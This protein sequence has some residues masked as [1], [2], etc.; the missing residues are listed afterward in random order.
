MFMKETAEENG[1]VMIN[2]GVKLLNKVNNKVAL[3]SVDIFSSYYYVATRKVFSRFFYNWP[4][5]CGQK[6]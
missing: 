6:R 3:T 4:A 2:A 1:R 5:F